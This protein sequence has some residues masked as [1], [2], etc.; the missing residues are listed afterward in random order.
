MVSSNSEI[1]TWQEAYD[2]LF[3]ENQRLTA[4]IAAL[5]KNKPKFAGNF[6]EAKQKARDLLT[7]VVDL[8]VERVAE[9]LVEAFDNGV[10][11]EHVDPL[12][13]EKFLIKRLRDYGIGIAPLEKIKERTIAI[14]KGEVKP[15]PDDPKLWFTSIEA[16]VETLGR[17]HS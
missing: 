5:R 2:G 7:G 16:L 10:Y 11:H 17:V 8:D 6:S 4:Q 13:S 14:A 12:W 1:A 9:A 15:K 3:R